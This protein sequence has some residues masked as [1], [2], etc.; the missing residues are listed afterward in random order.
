MFSYLAHGLQETKNGKIPLAMSKD[1]LAF[2]AAVSW[3]D[4]VG[5]FENQLINLCMCYGCLMT[6]PFKAKNIHGKHLANLKPTDTIKFIYHSMSQK[7]TVHQK[8]K[9]LAKSFFDYCIF[10]LK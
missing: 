7:Q 6:R 8:A 5:M 9:K 3:S 1:S 10:I 4:E 2:D